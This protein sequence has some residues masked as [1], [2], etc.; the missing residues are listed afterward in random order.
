MD[1]KNHVWKGESSSYLKFLDS[2]LGVEKGNLGNG[3]RDFLPNQ[4]FPHGGEENL[5]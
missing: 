5:G 2:R 3:L 4:D 1:G